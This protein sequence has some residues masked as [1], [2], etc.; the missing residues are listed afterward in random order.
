MTD[1]AFGGEMRK[2][3]KRFVYLDSENYISYDLLKYFYWYVILIPFCMLIMGSYSITHNGFSLKSLFPILSIVIWTVAYWG[4]VL[5]IKS[6]F[7]KNTFELR[8][9]VNGAMGI[10]IS[11][12]MWI[13]TAA[14]N[15][16]ADTPFLDFRYFL[17]MIPAYLFISTIYIL[18]IVVNI[19][20][21]IYS[22]F[23]IKNKTIVTISM[24][25]PLGVLASR[26]IQNETSLRVQHIVITICSIL[27][28]F[29]PILS[30]INFLK[31]YYCKKYKI[32]CDENGN[33]TSPNLEC[34]KQRTKQKK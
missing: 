27:L 2:K 1:A 23:R 30:Y 20:N 33:T 11:S 21:G 12:L 4:M 14:W 18:G 24:M 19:H 5:T 29:V 16:L 31:Y 32:L 25:V 15:L 34:K 8:F 26:F 6:K 7:V 9:F 10:L 13:F 17:W 28:I 3:A 22:G